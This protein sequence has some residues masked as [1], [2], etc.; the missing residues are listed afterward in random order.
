[1]A[2]WK[3]GTILNPTVALATVVAASSAFPPVLSPLRLDVDERDF[4]PN[5]GSELQMLPYTTEIVLS[6][7]G[8][9]DNLGLETAWK[10]YRTVLVSDGGGL[11]APDPDPHGDWLGIASESSN[12]STTK[13]VTY[14]SGSSSRPIDFLRRTPFIAKE[15][16]GGSD[17]TWLITACRPVRT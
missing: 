1:M 13:C 6:D 3:V 9:Y 8:V 12:S 17:R 11:T 5:S 14:G 16:T 4:E 7:G 2:D 15:P 10:R